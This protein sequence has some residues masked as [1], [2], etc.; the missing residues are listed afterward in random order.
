MEIAIL[1]TIG[2]KV[3]QM[4]EVG[5]LGTTPECQGRGYASALVCVATDVVCFLNLRPRNYAE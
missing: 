1:E 2:H 5:S 4:I 3:S